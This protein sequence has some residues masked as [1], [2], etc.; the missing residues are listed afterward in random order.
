M[1]QS[2]ALWGWNIQSLLTSLPLISFSAV[3]GDQ[4]YPTL[5]GK[6]IEANTQSVFVLGEQKD[7]FYIRNPP[8]QVF[9]K[10]SE[11]FYHNICWSRLETLFFAC[12]MLPSSVQCTI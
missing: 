6:A 9:A 8:N 10:A 3:L 12:N 4:D 11:L 7:V 5:P 1:P 2:V